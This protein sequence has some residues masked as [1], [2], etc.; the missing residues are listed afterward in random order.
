[1]AYA[2]RLEEGETFT[3]LELKTNY[4]RAVT[5]GTLIATGRVVHG[6]RTVG[7]TACDVVDERGTEDRARDQHLHD[8][9]RPR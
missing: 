4:L 1:M 3:T 7:L 2:S 9:A 5:E 6:G 8:A